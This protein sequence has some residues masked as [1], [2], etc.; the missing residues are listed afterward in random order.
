[1]PNNRWGRFP[2]CPISSSASRRGSALLTVL[3]LTAAL[4]AI[5]LAVANNV[6]GETERASTNVDDTKAYFLA[7]GAIERALLHMQWGQDF[8]RRGTPLMDLPFPNGQVRVESSQKL[9]N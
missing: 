2:I 5:G 1:M 7:R 8:Y 9:R 3:W 6:R 4:A